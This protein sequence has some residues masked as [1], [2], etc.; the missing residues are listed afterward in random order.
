MAK[1]R[2]F[3]EMMAEV[4]AIQESDDLTGSQEQ[5]FTRYVMDALEELSESTQCDLA[6]HEKSLGTPDQQKLNGYA[7]ND[8]GEGTILDLYVTYFDGAANS[9][10]NA[11]KE[12]ITKAEKRAANVARKLIYGDFTNENPVSSPL[13]ELAR[14]M[15]DGQQFKE[16]LSKIRIFI[17]TNGIYEGQSPKTINIAGYAISYDVIDFVRLVEFKKNELKPIEIDA[18]E[19]LNGTG[20]SISCMKANNPN[21]D[22]DVYVAVI[23][24]QFLVSIYEQYD[25]RLM[26]QNVRTFLMF[27]RKNGANQGMRTTIKDEPARF[28]AYNNGISATADSIE[29][30]ESGHNLLKIGNLQIV[31]GGQTTGVIYYCAKRLKMDVSDVFVQAKISVI[32]NKQKF[33][34]IVENI[35]RYANTQTK[36][37]T[38]D[39]SSNNESLKVFE[40]F[41]NYTLVPLGAPNQNTYWFFERTRNQYANTLAVEGFTPSLKKKFQARKPKCQ[42]FNKERLALCVNSYAEVNKGD[43]QISPRWSVKGKQETFSRFVKHILPAPSKI[44]NIFFEDSIA[45]IIIFTTMEK[46]YGKKPNAI[47]DLRNV[48]VPYTLSLFT[49]LT[50]SQLDLYKIWMNQSLS[51]PLQKALYDLMV[52]VNAFI[53]AESP[54]TNVMEWTRASDECW[55]LVKK[56]KD[57]WILDCESIKDDM[58]IPGS[59]RKKNKQHFNEGEE[60][61]VSDEEKIMAIPWEKWDEIIAWGA[62]SGLLSESQRTDLL[63]KIRDN[64]KHN[65]PLQQIYIGIRALELVMEHKPEILDSIE[66]PTDADEIE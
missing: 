59:K 45:K 55:K 49:L 43:A 20:L 2:E 60:I 39:F 12:N 29:L 21:P 64:I 38:A 40:R 37:N 31:N 1:E 11:G 24:A 58:V 7:I 63:Y 25:T 36:V 35:S 10:F 41:T 52:Q 47:G 8:L 50:D 51:E 17:V 27:S 32:H 66:N 15:E 9:P 34:E 48:V 19:I 22:Y 56:N 3:R 30:D 53:L 5:A 42:A 54:K 14:A 44:D 46:L 61:L 62:E 26:Q 33:A 18:A 6:Y 57:N 4:R 16:S 65:H 23:P 13:Y 28:L